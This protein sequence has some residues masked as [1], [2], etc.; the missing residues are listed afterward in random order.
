MPTYSVIQTWTYDNFQNI[1]YN[2][3]LLN[4]PYEQFAHT[5]GETESLSESFSFGDSFYASSVYNFSLTM[6]LSEQTETEVEIQSS[7]SFSLSETTFA[8]SVS[9]LVSEALSVGEDVT[10]SLDGQFTQRFISFFDTKITGNDVE[11]N[12]EFTPNAVL[13]NL[14]IVYTEQTERNFEQYKTRNSPLGYSEMRPL[15]PGDYEYKDAIVG[16]QVR[17]APPVGGAFIVS[18]QKLHIDVEDVVDKGDE[19]Y[20]NDQNYIS[21]DESI[22]YYTGGKTRVWFKKKFYTCPS[23]FCEVRNANPPCRVSMSN[24]DIRGEGGYDYGYFEFELVDFN[25]GQTW[26]GECSVSWQAIGY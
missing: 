7:E 19:F 23:V 16:I 2:D 21:S 18:G 17:L 4:V 1:L 3:P 22:H 11:A 25:N 13:T 20:T 5:I 6:N 26:Q 12:A 24:V 9:S 15:Y 8:P 14:E 10:C